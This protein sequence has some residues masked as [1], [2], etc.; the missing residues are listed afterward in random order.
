MTVSPFDHPFLSALLG[1]DEMAPQFSIEA[2]YEE[3]FYFE[4]ALSRALAEE[5]LIPE[6]AKEIGPGPF[7]PD[8]AKLNAGVARDGV[9][10]PEYVR[11]LREWVGPPAGEF[12]HYGA[13]SQDLVDTSLVLRLR[14]ILT[15]FEDRLSQLAVSLAHLDRRFGDKVLMGRTR[16]Q[17]AIPISGRDRIAS[18]HGPVPRHIDRLK[19]LRPRVLVLQ[20]G[21]AAG[22]LDK[23]G[24]KADAVARR[25]AEKL[26]LGLP[27]R[28][29][30]SQRDN[31]V[32][33]GDWLALVSGS[34]GKIGQD[35][36]LMALLGEV[37][38]AGAGGSSSM[39]HKQNPVAAEALV[40]L[41]R[42]SATLVAG[43]HQA[44]VHEFERSGAA[45]TLEWLALPQLVMTTGAGLRLA[46]RLI[47]SI[48]GMG[49]SRHG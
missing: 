1:D 24:D 45:W 13:T 34:L 2:D 16:M 27:D 36:A 21:G 18:W 3:M 5:G 39:T 49:D 35:I 30:H 25:L 31:L 38:I 28:S 11:Q 22:T 43:L 8:L 4:E 14:P 12:V 46:L 9:A 6:A 42:Y 48:A 26:D 32:E 20:F 7:E 40:A 29:W 44:Q 19:A 23:L 33:F 47:G 41:A 15:E 37:T 10:G 17:D